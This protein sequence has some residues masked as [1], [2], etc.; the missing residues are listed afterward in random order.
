MQIRREGT[1]CSKPLAP[2]SMGPAS[3]AQSGT[4]K[5]EDCLRT[6]FFQFPPSF[7]LCGL[8][9]A[10]SPALLSAPG[11]AKSGVQGGGRGLCYF[12]MSNVG[13]A[14][15]WVP[16]AAALVKC[17]G[18]QRGPHHLWGC[19][20]GV[21]ESSAQRVPGSLLH[22]VDPVRPQPAGH[23]SHSDGL[24]EPR[25]PPFSCLIPV[26]DI[27]DRKQIGFLSLPS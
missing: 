16:G 11:Y 20:K 14:G 26:V 15:W 6:S 17:L 7:L 5:L 18:A 3:P 23:P 27:S 1:R 25:A 24:T 22:T 10:A 2:G 19:G 9:P 4:I 21:C 8:S 13:C 12:L